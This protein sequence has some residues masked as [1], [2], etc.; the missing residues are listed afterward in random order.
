[1]ALSATPALTNAIDRIAANIAKLPEL[2]RNPVQ[3]APIS[4]P[5]IVVDYHVASLVTF[6]AGAGFGG[7]DEVAASSA[8]FSA[9]GPPRTRSWASPTRLRRR[10]G[11]PFQGRSIAF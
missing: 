4:L 8:A 11:H 7:L 9:A 5:R 1:M 6:L 10:F 2:V 3:T